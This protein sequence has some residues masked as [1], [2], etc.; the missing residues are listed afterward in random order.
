MRERER[1]RMCFNN[2]IDI[3]IIESAD[4]YVRESE[5]GKRLRKM[6]VKSERILISPTLKQWQYALRMCMH[7]FS[8]LF[9]CAQDEQISERYLFSS[10]Y[11]LKPVISFNMIYICIFY[12]P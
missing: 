11:Y 9:H 6:T 12:D 8:I 7:T 5:S 2:L 3:I 10:N 4:S 1:E